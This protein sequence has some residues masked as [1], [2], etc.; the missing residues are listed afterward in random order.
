MSGCGKD[1][2]KPSK[3]IRRW[4]STHGN[5]VSNQLV[6][7]LSLVC[8]LY[9]VQLETRTETPIRPKPPFSLRRISM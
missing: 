7:C 1:V 2:E 8:V 4:P 9:K 6:P 3:A 5:G